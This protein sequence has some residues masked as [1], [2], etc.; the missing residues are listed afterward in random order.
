M[1]GL[2]PKSLRDTP[3]LGDWVKS[4]DFAKKVMLKLIREGSQEGGSGEP[5]AQG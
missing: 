2:R 1:I 4:G 3:E 5:Q